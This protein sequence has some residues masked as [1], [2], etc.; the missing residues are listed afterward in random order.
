MNNPFAS[1]WLSS[2][3]RCHGN[4][5][6]RT[7]Q[8]S[9]CIHLRTE[10]FVM[11]LKKSVPFFLLLT[12]FAA[13][14][15]TAQNVP[16]GAVITIPGD[17]F[18]PEGITVDA[19][20]AFYIGSMEDGSVARVR[21]GMRQA[22]P[23]IPSG[24]NGLVSVLGVLADDARG[25]LWVCSSDAGNSL[26]TGTA[27]VGIK[28]FALETGEPVGSYDFPDGGFCN[29]LTLDEAGNLYASDSW[30]PRILRLPAGGD[31]LEVWV[32]DELFGAEQWS[33]NGLDVSGASLYIVNQRAGLLFR[34]GIEP[35]G[36]AG[37]ITQLETS[38]AL[39]SPDGL[40]VIGDNRLLTA[41]GG[42]GGMALLTLDG[43]NAEVTVLSEGL[44]GVSTFA[45]WENSAWLLENQGQ[46]FWD[47]ANAGPDAA[48]PFRI[49]EIPIQS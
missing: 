28:S 44:S 26:L 12:V 35:D 16:R 47:P 39:R 27:P 8:N 30:S 29:D 25:L 48:L 45:Y 49:I 18:F 41:E 37:L 46:H 34:V 40:K 42:G 2:E 5:L 43:D 14:T 31:A 3:R 21:P 4:E 1:S 17:R 7:P 22:E 15:V 19:S 9:S 6:T 13:Y 23:F 36:S 24:S 20:G 38:Q 10:E 32:E 33:L 11:I